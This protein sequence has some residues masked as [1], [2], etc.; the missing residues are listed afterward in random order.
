M[1]DRP[2]PK[3]TSKENNQS[4]GRARGAGGAGEVGRE[5]I[6]PLVLDAGID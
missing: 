1:S 3:G 4:L 5:E 6:A 2:S